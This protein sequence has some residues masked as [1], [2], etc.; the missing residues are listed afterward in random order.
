MNDG[1]IT[2][3]T[4]DINNLFGLKE[5]VEALVS[6]VTEL[7]QSSSACL[8]LL[9]NTGEKLNV[10]S[11]K[12]FS[13]NSRSTDL[14]VDIQNPAID[15]LI[16]KGEAIIRDDSVAESVVKEL[17]AEVNGDID[18]EDIDIILPLISSDRLIGILLF[19][20]RD[21]GDY[22]SK[23]IS[24]LND[25]AARLAPGMEKEYLREQLSERQ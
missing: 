4:L 13:K 18:P 1:K 14:S 23:E 6:L 20:R 25:I 24:V 15:Q 10:V 7:L 17:L 2:E 19:E 9:D 22:T 8:L 5:Q 21:S 3:V 16:R 11:G 12:S